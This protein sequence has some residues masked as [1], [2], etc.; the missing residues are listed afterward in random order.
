VKQNI[1]SCYESYVEYQRELEK[2]A[3]EREG[4]WKLAEKEIQ[5]LSELSSSKQTIGVLEKSL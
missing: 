2:S 3:E 5:M 4:R 1:V